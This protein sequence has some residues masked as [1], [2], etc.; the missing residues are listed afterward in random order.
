MLHEVK[1]RIANLIE[2]RVDESVTQVF[3]VCFD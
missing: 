2:L 3:G 1:R